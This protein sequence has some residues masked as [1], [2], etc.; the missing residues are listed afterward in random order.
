MGCMCAI[1]AAAALA[2]VDTERIYLSGRGCDDAVVW[3]FSFERTSSASPDASAVRSSIPVPSCWETQGFGKLQYGNAIRSTA[4]RFAGRRER[5]E[6]PADETGVYRRVFKI[7]ASAKGRHVDLVFEAVMTDCEATL[8]GKTVG[9]HQGGYTTFKFDVTDALDYG[10]ENELVVKVRKESRNESIND[11]ERR[12]DYWVFGGIWRPV[13]LEVKPPVF[14]EWVAVDAR[15]DG[16]LKADLHVSDGSVRHVE[17]ICEDVMPWSAEMPNLYDKTFELKD[18]AGRVLHRVT[19]RIGFRTIEAKRGGEFRINGKRV[20]VKGVNRHSFRPE[21]GRTLSREKNLEDVRLIKSMNMNAVRLSHYPADP[22]FLDLC[23][24]YGLYVENEFPGWQC[25][26]DT[27]AGEKLVREFIARD[28]AHPCVVW[29]SNGNEGGWNTAL[30]H[31]F[32]EMDP[33]KR[34][35]LH[36]WAE[37][38]AFQT[39]HYRNYG[40]TEKLLGDDLLYMPTEF[41]HGLYDGGHAAGLGEVWELFRNSRHGV[42]GFL[43]DFMDAGMPRK[44]GRLDCMGSLG[45]DGILGPHGE[46]SGSYWA[47]REI[48]SPVKLDFVDGRVVAENRCDF[49]TLADYDVREERVVIDGVS[50]V[51]AT[52]TDRVGNEVLTKCWDAGEFPGGTFRRENTAADVSAPDAF[53]PR[54]VAMKGSKAMR[55]QT[56]SAV[57]ADFT[58]GVATN[59]DNSIEVE[60][61]I[62]CTNAVD[63][64]GVTF[65][66]DE[67]KVASKRWLGNGPGRVWRNRPEGVNFGLWAN[68]YNDTVPGESWAY[69]EFKG[70]FSGVRW[71][72]LVMKDGSTLRMELLERAPAVG[73]FAPRDG[74]GAVRLY[75]MPPLGL[76]VLDIVPAVGNKCDPAFRA[77]PSGRSVVP[78]NPVH[79]RVRVFRTSRFGPVNAKFAPDAPS[80]VYPVGAKAVVEAHFADR[81][82]N[83]ARGGLVDIWADDGW[84]NRVW[85]RT[86]DLSKEAQPVR[87]ELT[88]ATPG[89][90]RLRARGRNV[91]VR[92]GMERIIFGVD[93]IKPL[94]PCPADFE[95]Y[96]RGEQRRLEKDVPFS[97]EK[98]LAP[99]LCNEFRDVYRVSFPTFNGKR[100]YGLL[101]IPKGCGDGP[102]PAIVNVPGAG[103]GEWFLRREI[104]MPGY[105]TLMM[106]LHDFP[107]CA[108][109]KEQKA[110]YGEYLAKLVAESGESKYQAYGFGT[111]RRDAPIYHDALL[112]MARAVEWLSRKP[113]VDSKRVVYYGCSQGGGCGILLTA[114]WGKF[115][116]SCILCP[117]MCDLLAF[118]Y[119]REPGSCEYVKNQS[120]AHRPAAEMVGPY[121]DACNFAR[122]I[123]TPVRML[124][125]TMDDNCN[126]TGGI[127]AFNSLAARDKRLV[128]LPGK[129][130]G[131]H[132][133]GTGLEEWLFD[134][135]REKD[136]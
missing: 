87:M 81:R 15:A 106:N 24:E 66:L 131:W 92:F 115:S 31:F 30:D 23:D 2:N 72:E 46:K 69:P 11:A 65:D 83:L 120:D 52:V 118:K 1:L 84:T 127:A 32:D 16:T 9:F 39:R 57:P 136:R 50:A 63:I 4:A 35:L 36:P 128:L 97:V 114:L 19:R 51:R 59:A 43:W 89:S 105:V 68:A 109:G 117:S 132:R 129:G 74:R 20:F 70:F 82:G 78:A 40:D 107:H 121:Y 34:P 33:S 27:A 58:F 79:G 73:V 3:D 53:I 101:G 56:F 94:S 26:V 38:G 7:P 37:L 17:E 88:R 134:N 85:S 116:K 99:E 75:T 124:Y 102:F 112:G 55:N 86:V 28:Q 90:L 22:D 119:G 47:V 25:P 44:D 61:T 113:S 14:I 10:G 5:N 67:R 125:G 54:L 103:P 130:H 48:W 41:Q 12:G 77:S 49:L 104:V 21:T 123:R 76:S 45:A 133:Q 18:D 93:E 110:R 6:C 64:L 71:M 98:T 42:G 100:I 13:Y 60:W 122:L 29:W 80:N 96:W 108:D 8:N 62:N 111:G 91:P 126:T 135:K 95:E